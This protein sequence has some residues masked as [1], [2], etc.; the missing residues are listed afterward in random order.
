MVFAQ[1]S[2][3]INFDCSNILRK[4]HNFGY[5]KQSKFVHFYLDKF[6]DISLGHRATNKNWIHQV[7]KEI[8]CHTEIKNVQL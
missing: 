2:S 5:F 1:L 3:M 6:S 8:K 4:T 7:N